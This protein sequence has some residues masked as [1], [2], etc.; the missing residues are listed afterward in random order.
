MQSWLLVESGQNLDSRGAGWD[1]KS[2]IFFALLD[3]IGI[4]DSLCDISKRDLFTFNKDVRE[5]SPLSFI[6]LFT[7]LVLCHLEYFLG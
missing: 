6:E 2:S 4:Y 3:W 7:M 5:F 1:M